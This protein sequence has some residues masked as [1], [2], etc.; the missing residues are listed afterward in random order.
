MTVDETYA[1]IK[2]TIMYLVIESNTINLYMENIGT[3]DI[4]TGMVLSALCRIM[5]ASSGQKKFIIALSL[6]SMQSSLHPV[7][8]DNSKI[9][10]ESGYPYT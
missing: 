2:P 6:S 4:Q 7:A 8:T 10:L 9:S 3:G 1:V 5:S